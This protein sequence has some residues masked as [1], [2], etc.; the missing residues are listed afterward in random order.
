MSDSFEIKSAAPELIA[1]EPAV[2]APVPLRNT[3]SEAKPVAK[4]AEKPAAKTP[5]NESAVAARAAAVTR[6]LGKGNS[7]ANLKR[8][9]AETSSAVRGQTVAEKFLARA[10]QRNS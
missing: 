9:A 3:R 1:V 6:N 4:K 10:A 5:A 2:V 8:E 7:A